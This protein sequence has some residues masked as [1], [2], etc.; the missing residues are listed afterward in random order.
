MDNHDK[1]KAYL[2]GEL[3]LE[4]AH[5]FEQALSE[6]PELA[7]AFELQHL[8][9]DLARFDQEELDMEL[10]GWLPGLEALQQ[11]GAPLWLMSLL[12]G[13]LVVGMAGARTPARKKRR[14]P[15]SSTETSG[16]DR[17]T[18]DAPDEGAPSSDAESPPGGR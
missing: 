5:A 2:A 15:F 14:Q 8:E 9:E 1:I 7:M 10:N 4:E 17:H 16:I 13:T 11:S 6:E 3:P 12:T 18:K